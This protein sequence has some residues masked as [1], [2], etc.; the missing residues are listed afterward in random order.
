MI[1]IFYQDFSSKVTRKLYYIVNI[2]IKLHRSLSTT[3]FL[4]G[5]FKMLRILV[6]SPTPLPSFQ[7]TYTVQRYTR[8]ELQGLGIKMDDECYDNPVYSCTPHYPTEFSAAVPY[9]EQQPHHH[10][11]HHPQHHQPQAPHHQSYFPTES[12]P[13]PTTAVVPPSNHRQD[14]SY[15]VAV[16][17]PM[18]YG[19]P[20]AIATP[21]VP[22]DLCPNVDTVVIGTTRP[23][24][25]SLP[26]QRSESAR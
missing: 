14:P 6:C 17:M 5:L 2:I 9:H 16:T 24:R 19:P 20:S 21:V 26:T 8:Q 13:T 4:L 15:G 11:H 25:A 7:E 22:T 10:H 18:V 12:A 23:R 1:I 3:D